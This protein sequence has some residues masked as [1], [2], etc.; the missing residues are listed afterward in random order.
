MQYVDDSSADTAQFIEIVA[1]N[2]DDQRAVGAA[3]RIVDHIDDRLA[4]ADRKSRQL[5]QTGVEPAQEFRLSIPFGPGIVRLQT[6][7]GFDVGRRPCIGAVVAAAKLCDSIGY[8][9]KF[10]QRAP[11][12]PG[13][14]AGL[15]E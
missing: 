7:G 8:F 9:G 13:H 6:D 3:D 12:F 1:D 10:A 14:L 11:Q 4:D 5:L 15:V 2:A